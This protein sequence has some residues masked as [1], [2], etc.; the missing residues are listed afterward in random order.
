MPLKYL[1]SELEYTEPT[2]SREYSITYV[3]KKDLM[4]F[5]ED[6]N[7]S[8]ALPEDIVSIEVYYPSTVVTASGFVVGVI[9]EGKDINSIPSYFNNDTSLAE[10]YFDKYAEYDR[11][12]TPSNPFSFTMPRRNITVAMCEYIDNPVKT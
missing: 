11:C 10:S 5:K 1:D 3:N 12:Y 2:V 8:S 9:K 4:H 7:P 6:S